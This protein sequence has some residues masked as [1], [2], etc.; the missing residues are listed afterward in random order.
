MDD[1]VMSA[2]SLEISFAPFSQ[3]ARAV[4]SLLRVCT[5]RVLDPFL[6]HLLV[7][8]QQQE[9]AEH[10]VRLHNKRQMRAGACLI[11]D[12]TATGK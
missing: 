3:A 10:D 11:I 12:L 7:L 4:A 5:D 2:R 6:E 1:C 9:L 8:L